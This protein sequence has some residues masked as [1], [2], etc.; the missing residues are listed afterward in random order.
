M[1]RHQSRSKSTRHPIPPLS[2][3]AK[4]SYFL[5]RRRPNFVTL[6]SAYFEV[7]D[8]LMVVRRACASY[9]LKKVEMVCFATPVILTIGS[10]LA[11]STEAAIAET[12]LQVAG[13]SSPITIKLDNQFLSIDNTIV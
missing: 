2:D 6:K 1:C 12:L 7:S 10:I 4:H 5:R 11:P 13:C 3:L 8:L 9:I